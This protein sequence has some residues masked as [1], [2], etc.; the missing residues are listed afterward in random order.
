MMSSNHDQVMHVLSFAGCGVLLGAYYELFRIWR[1]LC[2]PQKT[3][4]LVADIVYCLTG[5]LVVFLCSLAIQNGVW[6]VWM[7]VGLAVGVVAWRQ[8][9]GRLTDPFCTVWRACHRLVYRLYGKTDA[10]YRKTLK[11]VMI[12]L[13]KG[14]HSV[15][16]LVYNQE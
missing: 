5:G 9:G 14:L 12:F 6:D 8:T 11:K 13:K 4:C 15:W 2:H 7:F 10:M 1:R 16:R 3:W